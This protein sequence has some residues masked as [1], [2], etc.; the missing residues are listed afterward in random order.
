VGHENAGTEKNKQGGDYL[1]HGCLSPG[2]AMPRTALFRNSRQIKLRTDIGTIAPSIWRIIGI[3]PC[4]SGRF[5][6]VR[7]MV[8][9]GRLIRPFRRQT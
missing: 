5:R 6:R 9:W 3:S 7:K 4:V 8:S 1:G 2:V